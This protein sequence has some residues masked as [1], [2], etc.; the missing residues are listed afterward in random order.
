MSDTIN[1]TTTTT[2]T[3]TAIFIV[4]LTSVTVIFSPI[5]C[6]FVLDPL[7]YFLAMSTATSATSEEPTY[8]P[9]ARAPAPWKLTAEVYILFHTLTQLPKGV[10]AELEGEA[11]GWDGNEKGEFKG[12]L[13]SVM[14]VR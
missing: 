10:H 13:G 5:S 3:T 4:S 14:V 11:G 7:V 6:H 1:L 8:H 12:G 9:V 2:I